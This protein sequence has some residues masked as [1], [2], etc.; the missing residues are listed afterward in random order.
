MGRPIA[1]RH[2]GVANPPTLG[3]A[4][5]EGVA[6]FT[7]NNRGI[8]YSQG[9]TISS[10]ASPIG[11]AAPNLRPVLFTANGSISS[12]TIVSPGD[13][14]LTAPT[15]TFNKPANVNVIANNVG[16]FPD[17]SNLQVASTVGIF[18]G[19]F[20][21]IGGASAVITNVFS[22]GNVRA[23][24]SFGNI[25]ANTPARFFDNGSGANVFAILAP[26][27][28]TANTIQA[29]AWTATG[30]VGR[31]SDIVSQ[32]SAR[33]YRVTNADGTSVCTLRPANP[34]AAGQM[35]I[36]ATDSAGGTY[37]VLK[38]DSRTATLVPNTG[39]QFANLSQIAWTV[40]GTAVVNSG[41]TTNPS[42][43]ARVKLASND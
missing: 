10:S 37:W 13:G 40:T 28:T 27:T 15:L 14:Y 7:F 41:T 30:A 23:N 3:G 38:L 5:G 1:R 39:T 4:G 11:G 8:G 6:S 18:V 22:D 20:A 31:I 9:L 24:V 12:I 35:S 25:A 34:A 2:I 29:N 16:F 26:T 33:R 36:T 42:V 32:R 21:N 17:V 19:M 43:N